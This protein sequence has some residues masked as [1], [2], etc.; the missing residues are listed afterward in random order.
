MEHW[1]IHV[2]TYVQTYQEHTKYNLP[3]Y[4]VETLTLL[5]QY[6]WFDF[7]LLCVALSFWCL[8]GLK[9]L[10]LMYVLTQMAHPHA[11]F[12]REQ[13]ESRNVYWMYVY[14]MRIQAH[15]LYMTHLHTWRCMHFVHWTCL[16]FSVYIISHS[17]SGDTD[18]WAASWW[19]TCMCQSQCILSGWNNIVSCAIRRVNDSKP[20]WDYYW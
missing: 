5:C 3:V 19:Y 14:W 17:F 1:Y 4:Q 15:V 8:Y 7:M 13:H 20:Q 6:R 11:P 18:Y 16:Y 2:A 12:V 10:R 9:C